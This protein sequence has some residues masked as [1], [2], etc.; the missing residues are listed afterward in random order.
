MSH[1]QIDHIHD[2]L[3]KVFELLQRVNM[4][5]DIDEAEFMANNI[6]CNRIKEAIQELHNDNK[7]SFDEAKALMAEYEGIFSDG[8]C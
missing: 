2:Q 3:W 8:E 6:R 5:C 1:T 7:S 4:L